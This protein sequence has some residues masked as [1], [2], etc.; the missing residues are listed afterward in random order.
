MNMY[1]LAPTDLAGRG[2]Q[3]RFTDTEAAFMV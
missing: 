1:L 3:D 2:T